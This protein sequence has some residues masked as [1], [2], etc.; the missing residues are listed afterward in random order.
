MGTKT[1][2]NVRAGAAAYLEPNEPITAVLIASVRGHQQAMAGGV[3]GMIGGSRAS[4][5]RAA[6]DASGIRLASPMAL[7]LTR[8]RMLTLRTGG[9]GRVEELLNDFPLAAVDSVRVKR[10]GLGASVTIDVLSAAVKL[11]SRV[12]AARA[13][14]TELGRLKA[15]NAIR[16]RE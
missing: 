4:D 1:E 14:A 7:V 15:G 8:W 3:A 12:G 9:R 2:Q 5:A 6:A 11:E 13:L 16:E 10:L